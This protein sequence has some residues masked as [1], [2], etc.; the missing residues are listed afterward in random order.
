VL[1]TAGFVRAR[2]KLERR[3][4]VINVVISRLQALQRAGLPAVKLREMEPPVG[5]ATRKSDKDGVVDLGKHR[6]RAAAEL[7]A[8]LP[9]PHSWGRRGR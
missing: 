2:G 8:A 7:A 9:A 6:A 3:E 4:G 5:P 1:R